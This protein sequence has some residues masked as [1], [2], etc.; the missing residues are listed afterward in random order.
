MPIYAE[1]IEC[2]NFGISS[3]HMT[4]TTQIRTLGLLCNRFILYYTL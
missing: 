3:R 2:Q 1:K 4:K